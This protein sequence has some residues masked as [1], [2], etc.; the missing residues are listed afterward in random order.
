MTVH[1]SFSG[2]QMIPAGVVWCLA[3]HA[4]MMVQAADWPQFQ[5]VAR[6]SIS[7]E[8]GLLS[9]WPVEGPTLRWTVRNSGIGYSSPVVTGDRLFISGSQNGEELLKCLS[10]ATGETVWQQTIGPHFDFD[11]NQWGG[12]PRAT[13]CVSGG[14]VVA[15]G[16]GGDLICA[17]AADGSL[18]WSL[19]M[20]TD[21]AGEVNPV[22]GGTGSKPGEPKLGWGYCWSPLVDGKHL[23]VFPGGP[24]G[25]VAALELSSGRIVWRSRDFTAQ[26]SYSS[27]IVAEI[28]GVRQYIILHNEG[29]TGLDAETG[30]TLWTWEKSYADV[31][32]PT[33]ICSNG[34][35]YVSAGYSPATCDL[36]QVRRNGETFVAKNVYDGRAGR[37]MKN[38]V[39][40]S[41]LVGDHVYGYSGKVGWVCQDLRSG[42]QLWAARQPLQAGSVVA[43]DGHLYCYDEESGA[44]ALVAADPASFTIKGQLKLP[45]RSENRAISGRCWTPPVISDGNL[46]VRD[47]ELLH[48]YRIR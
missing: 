21:L 9:S 34:H 11:G 48:C 5:G 20:M 25:A 37:V 41:V 26:A 18:K 43:A 33:P 36:I 35:V 32:I 42:A 7:A 47:Q 22:G 23:I 17:D 45:G 28:E 12:G 29:L 40:G 19:H 4:A 10:T 46:Y 31:V 27:P 24:Q 8:T 13:P 6:D 15:L 16:G 3:I 1:H 44:V 2:R 30:E 39:G 38:M 14:L